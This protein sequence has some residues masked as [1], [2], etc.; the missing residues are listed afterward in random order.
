ML[1]SVT[2]VRRSGKTDRV[3]STNF[4]GLKEESPCHRLRL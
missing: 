3:H 1:A 4:K 2:E